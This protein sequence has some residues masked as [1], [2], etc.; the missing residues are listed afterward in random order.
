MCVYVCAGG[1]AGL[2]DDISGWKEEREREDEEHEKER[3]S[4]HDMNF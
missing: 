2:N 3:E 4:A 1:S